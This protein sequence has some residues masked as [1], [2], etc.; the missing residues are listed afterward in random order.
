MG[1]NV[2]SLCVLRLWLNVW[3]LS[4]CVWCVRV[5]GR[6]TRWIV[7]IHKQSMDTEHV[8]HAEHV[9]SNH[10]ANTFFGQMGPKRLIRCW[11]I[12]LQ[13]VPRCAAQGLRKDPSEG[14]WTC[15]RVS[16]TKSELPK[17]SPPPLHRPLREP[18]CISA[19]CRQPWPS[20]WWHSWAGPFQRAVQSVPAVTQTDKTET[21]ELKLTG[22]ATTSQN[23][24]IVLRISEIKRSLDP[25]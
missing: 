22:H 15:T 4:F 9:V 14:T 19:L 5:F 23:F 11:I 21:V 20:F 25:F 13:A 18:P 8:V 1:V 2:C 10:P 3:C 16:Y 17:R 6:K 24:V 12:A 7:S